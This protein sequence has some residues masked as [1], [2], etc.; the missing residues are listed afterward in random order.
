MAITASPV[1]QAPLQPH[2]TTLD[3]PHLY[4]RAA[5]AGL[6][7]YLIRALYL[8]ARVIP[9]FGSAIP[10]TDVATLDGWQNTW[11]I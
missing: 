5:L 7:L 6:V 11:N 9:S 10:G 1:A 2:D 3:K 8:L 4:T